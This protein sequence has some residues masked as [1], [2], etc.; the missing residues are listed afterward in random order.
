MKIL[1]DTCILSEVRHPQGRPQIRERF[2]T[3]DPES[4]YL[5]VLTLGELTKGIQ[6]L[7]AGKRKQA[8]SLWLE[9][10]IET[11]GPR[12]IP[13]DEETA[14]IWGET[15]AQAKAQGKTIPPI[16]G[17]IAATA[18]QHG[19]RVMTVNTTDFEPTGAMILN[20]L[21]DT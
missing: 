7:P 3:L 20:P 1:V 19:M 14:R 16:D 4:L 10:I 18:I 5:S 11:A 9:A 15:T 8:L 17:L 2:A 12:I 13:V 6:Q 21:E